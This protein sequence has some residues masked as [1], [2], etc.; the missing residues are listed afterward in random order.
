MKMLCKSGDKWSSRFLKIH[1]P[2][3]PEKTLRSEVTRDKYV[4]SNSQITVGISANFNDKWLLNTLL[5]NLSNIISY[6][7]RAAAQPSAMW[8][9]WIGRYNSRNHLHATSAVGHRPLPIANFSNVFFSAISCVYTS[10][11]CVNDRSLKSEK[12][13]D[14]LCPKTTLI[15]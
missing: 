13:R 8:N 14:L 12:R 4:G 1:F 6:I 11:L 9:N 2:N 3:L 10:I 5:R 15:R 7:F